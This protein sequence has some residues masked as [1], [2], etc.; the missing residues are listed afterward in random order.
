LHFTFY[1]IIFILFFKF[2]GPG[3]AKK[4]KPVTPVVGG[5]DFISDG[6]T[7]YL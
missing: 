4:Q 1:G 5:P 7:A 6:S 3:P 2:Q